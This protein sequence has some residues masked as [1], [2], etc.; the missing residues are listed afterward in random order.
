MRIKFVFPFSV[1]STTSQRTSDFLIWFIVSKVYL[2][3]YTRKTNIRGITDKTVGVILDYI[4]SS[5]ILLS[6]VDVEEILCASFQLGLEPLKIQCEKFLLRDLCAENCIKMTNMGRVYSCET[7]V[8]EG[9]GFIV[10]NF[11]EIQ[12]SPE[13]FR[14]PSKELEEIIADDDLNVRN[15]EQVYN[16]IRVW[17][18]FDVQT[19]QAEFPN[20]LSHV[21]LPSITRKFL[22]GTIDKD[23]LVTSS[24]TSKALVAEAL[25]FKM[26]SHRD[27]KLLQ[28]E[29]TKRR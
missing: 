2:S 16:A 13:F 4:Y 15:E 26:A 25:T 20:L 29:R 10:D 21:R 3:R 27:K 19:R 14:L 9:Q 7:L 23:P 1:I 24:S 17:V 22:L 5:E 6:E 8:R 28:N 12:S 18:D 11:L